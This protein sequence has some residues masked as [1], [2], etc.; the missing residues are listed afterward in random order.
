MTQNKSDYYRLLQDVR[1]ND[2]WEEWI[3]Y[4]LD[5]IEKT[6]LQTIELIHKVKK[7]MVET[8]HKLRSELP[9][10]Y[11]QD[12]LNNIFRHPYTK[13]DFIMHDIGVSRLTA[14][15]YLDQLVKVG[16]LQKDKIGRQNYYI[17][18]ALVEVLMNLPTLEREVTV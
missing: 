14:S 12:L 13:I 11:S 18:N 2:N 4:I 17:N 16:I 15:K 6:A 10:I 3:L 9:K 8:K 1:D 7:L 5:A